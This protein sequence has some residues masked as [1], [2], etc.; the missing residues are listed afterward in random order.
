MKLWRKKGSHSDPMQQRPEKFG[1]CD[2]LSGFSFLEVGKYGFAG[3]HGVFVE[4]TYKKLICLPSHSLCI[5]C[6]HRNLKSKALEVSFYTSTPHN[7][8]SFLHN[9]RN[10]CSLLKA[11][12]HLVL[13]RR[14]TDTGGT[15][16][17]NNKILWVPLLCH[18]F[19]SFS[20]YMFPTVMTQIREDVWQN[21]VHIP[22]DLIFMK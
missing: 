13:Q 14:A 22:I 17:S 9:H 1:T 20:I 12:F 16:M 6:V 21:T 18:K 2:L 4:S 3:T 8:Q 19:Y 5:L 15:S 10:L 11:I 7:F